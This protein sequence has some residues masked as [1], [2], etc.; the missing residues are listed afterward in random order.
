MGTILFLN[1]ALR[2][3]KPSAMVVSKRRAELK[4]KPPD[5]LP[6]KNKPP[7]SCRWSVR[8]V[9]GSRQG[10]AARQPPLKQ[11][12]P[13]LNHSPIPKARPISISPSYAQVPSKRVSPELNLSCEPE[14]GITRLLK[15]PLR[16][17]ALK[18][19]SG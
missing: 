3:C 1:S 14:A 16:H 10:R 5:P 8:C 15:L 18:R 12:T 19:Y 7:V 11:G 9:D 6:S 4:Y 2:V 17:C 13:S